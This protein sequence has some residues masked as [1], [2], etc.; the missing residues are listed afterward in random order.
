MTIYECIPSFYPLGASSV[1]HPSVATKNFFGHCQISPSRDRMSLVE[2]HWQKEILHSGLGREQPL[3]QQF[4]GGAEHWG[5]QAEA[6]HYTHLAWACWGPS[7]AWLWHLLPGW[8]VDLPLPQGSLLG[9]SLPR[10]W[11]PYGLVY[12]YLSGLHF[13]C[14]L[15]C[16]GKKAKDSPLVV[17]S[18]DFVPITKQTA[19]VGSC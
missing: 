11:L 18:T 19:S 15:W 9:S 13:L 17:V 14:S 10:R 3:C 16:P 4:A 7:A 1:P 5:R 8:I 2:N 12:I 6:L